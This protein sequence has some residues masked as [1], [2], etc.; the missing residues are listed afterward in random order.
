M[1]I[2]MLDRKTLGDVELSLF[3]NYGEFISYDVTDKSQ[4]I[5]RIVDAEIVLTNKVIIGKEEMDGA[6]N[7][8]YI[9]IMATGMNNVDLE[10]AK[11][12]GIVVTN[13]SGYSTKIVAQHTF[14]LLFSVIEQIAYYDNYVKSGEYS[15]QPLFTN[16]DRSFMEISGKIWGIVGLGEIG[17]NVAKIAETF[18]CKVI[19]Y[20]TSGKNNNTDYERVGFESLLKNADIISV[21]APLTEA[22]RN[23]FDQNAFE[24]MK[25]SAFF[26]NVG[27]GPIVDEWALVDAIENSKI[28]GAGIDVFDI[29]PLPKNCPLMSIKNKDRIVMTPHIAW[30]STEARMRLVKMVIDNMVKF[31]EEN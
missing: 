30:A 3:S 24:Q 19:Y 26:I 10:Y 13:V 29:E 6:P 11:N 17:R 20:S 31:I 27:R 9:G 8:K 5:E 28:A 16:L 2:V 14:A 18:G 15:K 23:L 21:H 12:K 22:T 7:L 1:K 4:T 25:E